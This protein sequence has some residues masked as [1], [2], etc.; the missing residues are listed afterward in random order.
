MNS[1]DDPN[2]G[3]ADPGDADPGDAALDDATVD[4]N[5]VGGLLIEVFG[6]EMTTATVVCGTCGAVSQVA[7]LAVY[8]RE[9]GTVI[10]CRSCYTLLMAFTRIR[11]VT[12]V[13]PAG[14]ASL[15]PS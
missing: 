10:R 13:D 12:C 3:D 5:A 2:P 4:G 14:L 6:T 7:E 1:T 15:A 9:L 8:P 11:G